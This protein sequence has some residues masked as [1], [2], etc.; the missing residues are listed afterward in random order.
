VPVKLLIIAATA[1]L[2]AGCGQ[3]NSCGPGKATVVDVVDGDTIKLDSGETVR[4]LMVDT[5][6]ITNGKNDCY[7]AESR[8][9]NES[10]VLN[11]EVSLEYDVEC[12]DR[13]DR[14]LA[15]V[16]VGDREIN[17]LLLDRGFACLLYIPP[18]GA[19]R[20][21][22]FTALETNAKN[23]GKGLWGACEEVTCD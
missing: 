1:A 5:P 9:F 4:Y 17:S 16:S 18:N 13:F 22:E 2:C 14:L 8:D 3:D 7:G 10:L 11:Q 20:R 21:D 15:Y 6:E 23:E 19:D 12:E